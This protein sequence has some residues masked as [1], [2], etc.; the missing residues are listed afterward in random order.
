MQVALLQH[1]VSNLMCFQM[2]RRGAFICGLALTNQ[3][4]ILL[5]LP[6]VGMRVFYKLYINKVLYYLM[7]LHSIAW[8]K[9]V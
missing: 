4:T 6:A 9:L 5:F 3:H 2:L 8:L 1:C 7:S